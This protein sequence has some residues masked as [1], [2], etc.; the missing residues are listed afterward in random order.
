MKQ[1]KMPVNIGFSMATD[2]GIVGHRLTA[3]ER[4]THSSTT[5]HGFVHE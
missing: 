5:L 1:I 2:L 3:L 4:L